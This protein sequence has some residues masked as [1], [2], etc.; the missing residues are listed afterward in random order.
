MS[1]PCVMKDRIKSMEDQLCSLTAI[2]KS[3]KRIEVAIIGDDD[4]DI[5]GLASK[6]R[7]HEKQLN[8]IQRVM[9]IGSGA[10]GLTLIIW[11][12]FKEVNK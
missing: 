10:V 6:V 1:D 9:W 7:R 5:E 4:A 12:I 2:E 11:E 8:T 3:I